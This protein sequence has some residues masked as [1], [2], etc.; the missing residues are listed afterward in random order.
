MKKT[1]LLFSVAIITFA[2]CKHTTYKEVRIGNQIWMAE[3]LNVDHFRNGDPIPNIT[4]DEEW[5]ASVESAWCCYNNDTSYCREY[6]RLYNWYAVND[7]RGLAPEGWHIP[8]PEEWDELI[9]YLG[10]AAVAGG[11]MKT[12]EGW[13][14]GLGNGTNESGF[15]A[16]PSGARENENGFALNGL[17]AV[18][19]S[20]D[21][22]GEIAYAPIIGTNG[23]NISNEYGFNKSLGFSVRC[24]KD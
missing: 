1:L 18:W 23:N 15:G 9:N 2:S 10:G 20:S 3:N 19:W 21:N 14:D 8:T 5:F 22:D 11:K 12:T 4:L 13:A 17:V 6:G 7:P 16:L 24:I